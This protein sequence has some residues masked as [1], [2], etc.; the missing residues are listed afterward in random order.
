MPSEA[1]AS[2]V[3]Q[4]TL[5]NQ[6]SSPAVRKL[7]VKFYPNYSPHRFRDLVVRS[8]NSSSYVLE[9]GAGSGTNHQNHFDLRGVVARYI[10]VDPDPAV[11]GNPFLDESYQASAESLPF[12]DGTFDLVFHNFV[13]EH[14][15]NPLACN[16]EIARVL[17]SG[18]L[19]LF[20]TPNRLYYPC[21]AASM[22]P[23]WFHKFYVKRFASGR[24]QDEVFP[25]FYRL[26]D[27]KAI[28]RQLSDCALSSEIQ[29]HSLPPGYLRFSPLAFRIGILYERTVERL[30]PSLRGHL[31]VLAR[32][33]PPAGPEK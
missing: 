28:V 21:V 10:G 6:N 1:Q 13:A 7:L 17:K 14:F 23:H 31:I 30:F 5:E 29:Y 3:P 18:G 4:H 20:Q 2:A 33:L 12:P 24:S 15:A 9:I 8:V 11:L 26:N 27:A 32:K 19:L 16:R 25:T 22:T